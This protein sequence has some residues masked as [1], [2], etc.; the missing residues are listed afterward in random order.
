ME[1]VTFC[2]MHYYFR[3]LQATQIS[4]IAAHKLYMMCLFLLSLL[5]TF[6]VHPMTEPNSGTNICYNKHYFGCEIVYRNHITSAR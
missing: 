1:A 3:E 5:T 2:L 6:K 4:L